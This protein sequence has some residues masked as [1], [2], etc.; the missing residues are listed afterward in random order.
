MNLVVNRITEHG[1]PLR[2][3]LLSSFIWVQNMRSKEQIGGLAIGWER[4]IFRR[5]YFSLMFSSMCCLEIELKAFS[6]S[7]LTR[8]CSSLP[9]EDRNLRV[10]WT[11]ASHPFL[12][13]KPSWVDPY[14]HLLCSNS[15]WSLPAHF[16]AN[17]RSVLPTAMGQTQEEGFFE[18]EQVCSEKERSD[19]NRYTTAQDDIC[20]PGQVFNQFVW[21][22]VTHSNHVFDNL[23]PQFIRP[24]G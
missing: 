13:P 7:I 16:A 20:E 11:A 24:T 23:R 19:I 14:E 3:S 12:V 8:T 1:W 6:K 15:S 2:V 4:K 21:C 18:C 17:L 9:G 22:F 5:G 10:A